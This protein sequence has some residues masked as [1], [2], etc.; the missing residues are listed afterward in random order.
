MKKILKSIIA[1]VLLCIMMTAC[2]GNGSSIISNYCDALEKGREKMFKGDMTNGELSRDITAQFMGQELTTE[3]DG[4]VPL[5]IVEPFKVINL[6]PMYGEIEF[7]AIIKASNPDALP[8]IKLSDYI[9]VACHNNDPISVIKY[10]S[11]WNEGEV[12]NIGY[13]LNVGNIIQGG[14]NADEKKRSINRIVITE[15]GSEL[16]QKL[17]EQ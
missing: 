13:F 9:F 11:K 2:S 16:F 14:E 4:D 15:Y 7:E 3:L 17:N 6:S 5:E 12:Y 10:S 8:S 1:V